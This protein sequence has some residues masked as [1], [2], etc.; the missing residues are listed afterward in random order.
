MKPNHNL[1][2]VT[3]KKYKEYF[4]LALNYDQAVEITK[5][6][7]LSEKENETNLFDEHGSLKADFASNF[8]VEIIRI[9]LLTGKVLE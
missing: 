9:E 2:K 1:F 7:I 5:E 3:T 6:E 8:D 4:V